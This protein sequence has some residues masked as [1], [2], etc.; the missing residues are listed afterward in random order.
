MGSIKDF[1]LPHKFE[2]STGWS[3]KVYNSTSGSDIDCGDVHNFVITSLQAEGNF[4]SYISNNI[5]LVQD[6]LSVVLLANSSYVLR[7]IVSDSKLSG[8]FISNLTVTSKTYPL[9][10]MP[11]QWATIYPDIPKG[12]FQVKFEIYDECFDAVLNSTDSVN[13]FKA[14]MLEQT[15]IKIANMQVSGNSTRDCGTPLYETSV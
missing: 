10:S 7:V 15:T 14:T 4:S 8:T 2:T 11:S 12:K 5:G 6:G 1:I 3:T 13:G 9:L